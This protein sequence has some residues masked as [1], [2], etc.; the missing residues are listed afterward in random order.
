MKL[1]PWF[2]GLCLMAAASCHAAPDQPSRIPEKVRLQLKWLHQF[3]FAGFYAALQQGYYREAG[4][5]VEI[6]EARPHESAVDVVSRGDAEFGVH[7]SDLVVERARG[8][9]VR[10]LAAIFQHSPM[11][12]LARRD[13]GIDSLHDLANRRLLLGPDAAELAAYLKSEG[14]PYQLL[15]TQQ[16][17]DLKALLGG[18]VDAMP[19]Y[20]TD[21]VFLLEQAGMAF[22]QF[23]PRAAGIDFYGDVLFT[24]DRELERHPERVRRFVEASLR[25][26]YYALSHREELARHI[27]NQYSQR[28]SMEHLLFEAEETRRLMTPELVEIGHM[29]GGRW[30][31]IADTFAELGMMPANYPLEDF[32]PPRETPQDYSRYYLI[33]GISLLVL[34]LAVWISVYFS[35]LNRALRREVSER[36][37][38]QED[39]ERLAHTDALTGLPNRR[40]FM[41]QLAGELGRRQRY[42]HPL[43][44]LMLDMDHF[45]RINDQ[46]GH[47]V[48]DE[49]LRLFADSVQCCLRTQDVA[50][51]LGGEEFAILLPETAENVARPVA[52][53][54]R[55]RMEQTP[56]ATSEGNVNATVS[57][58]VAEATDDDDLESLL[59][60]A[61]QALYAA[62]QQGRNRVL[63]SREV[64]PAT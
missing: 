28:H 58:G 7:G 5:E 37:R 61:D 13:R 52:E 6:L 15:R 31:H 25:G 54:I 30:R 22:S 14:V 42:G 33:L 20:S 45:K 55:A 49:A 60:R 2:L 41:T 27:Y 24:S 10:A 19:A 48:G 29:H 21:Q 23:S 47:A 8:R 39:L 62:K 53:R 35:R 18:D 38:L 12:L 34:L 11:V 59:R 63:S 64:V 57:I 43:S 51:R 36:Q 1:F 26:W 9:P 46:W 32:L 3:Q 56:I 40:F 17:F 4:L 16:S 50:A 44:L